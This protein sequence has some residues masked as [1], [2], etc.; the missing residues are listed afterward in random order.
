MR[1]SKLAL[2]IVQIIL[3]SIICVIKIGMVLS[4]QKSNMQQFEYQ[5]QKKSN[6]IQVIDHKIKGSDPH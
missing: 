3:C 4:K 1:I 6:N 5:N 2:A